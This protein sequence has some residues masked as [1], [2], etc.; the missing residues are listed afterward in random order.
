[1]A[2]SELKDG[3]AYRTEEGRLL[4][5]CIAWVD[6]D[7]DDPTSF[8][9]GKMRLRKTLIDQGWTPPGQRVHRPRPRPSM[10]TNQLPLPWR[11]EARR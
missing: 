2:S 6:A 11:Q 7:A 9:R 4:E 1:M 8:H 3:K 5:A 10:L